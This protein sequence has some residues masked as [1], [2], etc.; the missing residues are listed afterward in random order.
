MMTAGASAAVPI[1]FRRVSPVSSRRFCAIKTL[2]QVLAENPDLDERSQMDLTFIRSE[3]DRLN[4]CVEQI[5]TFARPARKDSKKI[6]VREL[7]AWS[8]QLMRQEFGDRIRI[9]S[10]VASGLD[11]A[12]V[13]YYCGQQVV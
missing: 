5:L 10:S 7:S 11:A 12:M 4:N 6:A 9:E 2:V 1:S 13:D 8:A 3:I